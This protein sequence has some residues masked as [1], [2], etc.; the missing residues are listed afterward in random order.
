MQTEAPEVFD[1]G[2]ES[3][4]TKNCTA[5]TNEDTR[6]FGWQ[7]LLARRSGRNRRAIRAVLAQL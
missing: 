3:D 4:A 2:E 6:D 7:C 1:T 5:W